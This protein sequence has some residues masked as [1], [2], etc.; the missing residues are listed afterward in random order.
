MINNKILRSAWGPKDAMQQFF[1]YQS[2]VVA[3][4][5]RIDRYLH[6]VVLC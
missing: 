6:P 1:R 4:E 2:T 3:S 5:E